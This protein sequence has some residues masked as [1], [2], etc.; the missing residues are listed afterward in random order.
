MDEHPSASAAQAAAE[1]ELIRTASVTLGAPLERRRLRLPGGGVVELDGFNPEQRIACE[2]FARIGPLK[3]GQKRKLGNDILKL[4]LLERRMGGQWRK[5]LVLAGE[6]ALASLSRGSW[7]AQ[8]VVEFGV[9]IL[10]IR[11]DEAAVAGIQT[12]QT[13]QVMINPA[14]SV[15]ATGTSSADN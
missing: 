5:I 2:A 14:A 4:L 12:A 10:L 3:A 9:E 8:A 15:P 7:Q 1:S 13:R 11:L 6:Q